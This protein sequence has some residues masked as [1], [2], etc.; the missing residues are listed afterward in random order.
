M[1]VEWSKEDEAGWRFQLTG[2]ALAD[3]Y[4]H[5]HILLLWLR[6]DHKV[7]KATYVVWQIR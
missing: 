5:F 1:K 4:V 3:E 6:S 7:S 2:G